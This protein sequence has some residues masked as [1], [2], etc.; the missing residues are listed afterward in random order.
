MARN[1]SR[2]PDLARRFYETGP[3][4]TKANLARVLEHAA[5]ADQVNVTDPNEAAEH[6]FGLWQGFSNFQPSLVGSP[7]QLRAQL[8][9]RVSR[10][11]D[12][13]LLA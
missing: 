2:D 13:F 8:T 12:V 1:L 7:E 10:A 11:I 3:R 5:A 4:R 9:Q 6:L